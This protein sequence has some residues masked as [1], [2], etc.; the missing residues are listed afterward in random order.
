MSR[1]NVKSTYTHNQLQLRYLQDEGSGILGLQLI[2]VSK[3][4]ALEKKRDKVSLPLGFDVDAWQVQPLV[5]LHVAGDKYSGA[6]TQGRTLQHSPSAQELRY[7]SQQQNPTAFGSEIITSLQSS[8][9]SLEVDHIVQL[10]DGIAGLTCRSTIRNSGVVPVTLQLFT[11]YTLCGISPFASDDAPGRLRLHRFRSSWSQEGRHV[12]DNF[13]HLHLEPSWTRWDPLS[14][15]FGQVGS[16]PT[17][18]F[19]PT[20]LIEDKEI[21][22]FWGAQLA[23]L[24][25]WQ[26]EVLRWGAAASLAG[27]LADFEFGHWQKTLLPG[28]KFESPLA[29]LTAGVDGIE[30]TCETFLAL[31]KRIARP[32]PPCEADLPIIFNEFCTTWGKPTET[33]MRDIADRLKDSPI[34]YVVIDA[35][36]SSK[37]EGISDQMSNGDWEIERKRF[38]NGFG[39]LNKLIRSQ[40][41][42]PGIWFEFEVATEGSQ[43]Y[44]KTEHQLQRDGRVLEVGPRRYWDFRDPWV[45]EYLSEKVID[46]LRRENF[47]YLKVDYNDTIGLGCDC[48]DGLG[49]GLRM[50]LE[51]VHRFFGKLRDE[52]PD[53][54]I[55]NCSSGGHRLEPMMVGITSMSSFSDAHEG[56]EIPWIAANVQRLINPEKS[57]IWAVLR[58]ADSQQRLIYTLSAAF[59]GRFCISGDIATLSAQQWNSALEAMRL[60]RRLWPIIQNGS[61]RRFG[62]EIQSV[63]HL[64]GHQVVRRVAGN[65]ALVVWHAFRNDNPSFIEVPLTDG[66]WK[67]VGELHSGS[68]ATV[69]GSHLY[70][71]E[72]PSLSGGVVH[73]QKAE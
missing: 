46:F 64:Q 63:R 27:G 69:K 22:V 57:Q 10:F 52:L 67:I 18:S 13:E 4:G 17:R 49:E 2:P 66:D 72:T 73:L 36:W 33:S 39:E 32:S 1:I 19:F 8:R 50:H 38:P 37:K 48:P 6:F 24:G 31:Q 47:G 16:M 42:I 71:A 26:F 11:S 34:K 25:S 41:K 60:Y 55:E 15:R 43:A 28:E 65:E 53:L 5:G 30:G 61:S 44:L 68:P 9:H 54:V 56:E 62:Q 23:W 20:A 3:L 45:I 29:F 7:V 51:G 40:G 12:S 35:G 21:G 70:I 14:E 58:P 59:L